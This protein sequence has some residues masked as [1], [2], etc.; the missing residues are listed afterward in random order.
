MTATVIIERLTGS[1]GTRNTITASTNSRTNAADEFSTGDTASPIKIG[2]SDGSSISYSYWATTRLAVTGAHAFTTIDNIQWYTTN[3]YGSNS[4]SGIVFMAS[5]YVQATGTP[6][7]SGNELT[8]ASYATSLVKAPHEPASVADY[9]SGSTL[10][11][12]GIINSGTAHPYS[13]NVIHQV[14]VAPDATAGPTSPI[15]ITWQYDEV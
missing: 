14:V 1:D 9:T 15:T 11:V 5:G 6:A 8:D 4:V 7:T 10:A 12:S 3:D 13:Y 2:N